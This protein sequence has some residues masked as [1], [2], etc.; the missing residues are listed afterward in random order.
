MTYTPVVLKEGDKPEYYEIRNGCG[1]YIGSAIKNDSPFN[2][3][4]SVSIEDAE[5]NA[6]LW[7]AAP[8]LLE[9]LEG[10]TKYFAFMVKDPQFHEYTEAINAIAKAKGTNP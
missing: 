8:G 5:N 2:G 10:L 3:C 9:A 1:M 6:R 4:T 7:A